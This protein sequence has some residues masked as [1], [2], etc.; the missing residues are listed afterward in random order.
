LTADSSFGKGRE[1]TLRPA[2][3][4][5]KALSSPEAMVLS[6][7]FRAG[8][9]DP[10]LQPAIHNSRQKAARIEVVLKEA[11]QHLRVHTDRNQ[12]ASAL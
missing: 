4:L 11:S 8:D 9:G 7:S 6:E 3:S 12:M 5:G 1:A 10:I 2:L